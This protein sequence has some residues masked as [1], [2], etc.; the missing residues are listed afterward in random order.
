MNKIIVLGGVSEREREQRCVPCTSQER[1]CICLEVTHR[2]RTAANNKKVR[3]KVVAKRQMDNSDGTFE[4]ANRVYD[5]K[6]S[7][8]TIPTCGG[9]GIQP[10]V[11]K[12]Y[13]K[14]NHSRID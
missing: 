8:P 11:I 14:D 3:K 13:E 4:S 12:R 2:Q 9:G 1:N 6:Q 10:K 5:P 7:C